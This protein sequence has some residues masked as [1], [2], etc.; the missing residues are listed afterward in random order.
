MSYRLSHNKIILQRENATRTLQVCERMILKGRGWPEVVSSYVKR[1]EEKVWGNQGTSEK[2]GHTADLKLYCDHDIYRRE[3]PKPQSFTFN[4]P[5]ISNFTIYQANQMKPYSPR[6]PPPLNK[7][8]LVTST[9]HMKVSKQSQRS[10]EIYLGGIKMFAVGSLPI[11]QL[12]RGQ[13]NHVN[14]MQMMNHFFS[15]CSVK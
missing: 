2:W 7:L 9:E 12:R 4:V 14:G 8:R 15:F 11:Y 5:S 3:L 13:R 10:M 1:R 6:W